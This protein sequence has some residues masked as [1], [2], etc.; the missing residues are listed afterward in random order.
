MCASLRPRLPARS[1]GG[2]ICKQRR[3]ARGACRAE[4]A[5][6]VTLRAG[7]RNPGVRSADGRTDGRKGRVQGWP[8]SSTGGTVLREQTERNA[9]QRTRAIWPRQPA[10]Q[11]S[12]HPASTHLLPNRAHHRFR[13]H[14]PTLTH[15]PTYPPT[16]P[17]PPLN[18]KPPARTARI[19]LPS[20]AALCFASLLFS[21]RLLQGLALR[22]STAHLRGPALFSSATRRWS[23]LDGGARARGISLYMHMHVYVYIARGWAK[24]GEDGYSTASTPSS[25]EHDRAV[26]I[27]YSQSL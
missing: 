25:V 15:L 17:S 10:I 16:R 18:E 7:T 14:P 8:C 26:L 1:A 21:S 2:F 23:R 20:S 12:S 27:Q 4:H 3:H 19:A 6:S 24:P 11:P 22:A 5:R 9:T 13:S